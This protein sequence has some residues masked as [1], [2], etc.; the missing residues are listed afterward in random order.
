M[1]RKPKAPKRIWDNSQQIGFVQKA[2]KLRVNMELVARDGIKYI[3]L[4]EFYCRRDEVDNYKPSIK[5]L[6]IPVVLPHE[7]GTS[8][9]VA[10]N[11]YAMFAQA[12]KA[13][14]EFELYNEA[15][16]VYEKLKEDDK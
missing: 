6:V 11:F 7:D 8:T 10:E 3:N 9:S 13:A 5:G 15:N 14:E 4:R 1:A 12:M 16:A 2:P